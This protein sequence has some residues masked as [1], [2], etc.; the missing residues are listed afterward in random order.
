M[1]FGKDEE[2]PKFE[3]IIYNTDKQN[4]FEINVNNQKFIYSGDDK[5]LIQTDIHINDVESLEISCNQE[6]NDYIENYREISYNIIEKNL[7]NG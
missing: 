7:K 6:K 3:M 4:Y 2:N 1:F 5:Y